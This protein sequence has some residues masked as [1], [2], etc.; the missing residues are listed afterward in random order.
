M[1]TFDRGDSLNAI[2]ILSSMKSEERK[3]L[4]G[5]C[6]WK[7]FFD[8]Q[9]VFDKESDNCD[10]MFV[11][12]GKVNV[13]DYSLT[14]KEVS[15]AEIKEGDYFGEIAAI[16]GEPRSASVI[17]VGDCELAGLNPSR[18]RELLDQH[19]EISR[20]VMKR[21]NSIIRRSN[22][23]VMDLSTLN[24]CQRICSEILRMAKPDTAVASAW[25]IYPL[26]TQAKIASRVSVSRETV[27]RVFKDLI[28]GGVISKKGRSVFIPDRDK[29][30][31]L[32]K[33]LEN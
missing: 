21:L 20:K 14:G 6:S 2:A 17:A 15:F 27:A 28:N 16:D 12:R 3:A 11:V 10:V 5:G 26:P 8:K 1:E 13:T 19:P 29:L 4:A 33:R 32:I 9:V 24:A 31:L 22:E 23:R 25:S 30:E 7:N 18:F